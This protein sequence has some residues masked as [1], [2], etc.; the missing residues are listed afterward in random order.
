M[1]KH[2]IECGSILKEGQKFCSECG[3]KISE[4][5]PEKTESEKEIKKTQKDIEE[6]IE[7]SEDELEKPSVQDK[8]KIKN[9]SIGRGWLVFLVI[10]VISVI[11]LA[12]ILSQNNGLTPGPDG[13][14]PDPNLPD[15][16]GGG[17]NLPDE[18]GD[19]IPDSSDNCPT[20]YNPSQLDN[21]NDGQGDICDP[22]DDNDGYLDAN[23]Y[24]RTKNARLKITLEEFG[25][26]DEVDLFNDQAQVYFIVT[27]N[28]DEVERYPSG[29]NGR[30]NVLLY[31]NRVINHDIYYD[32]PDNKLTHTIL[33]QMY[34][35]D[36]F[37]DPSD[38]LLDL[39]GTSSGGSFSVY[40][41]IQTESWTGDDTTGFTDGS[42]DGTQS[43]DNDDAYLKYDIQMV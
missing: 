6:D 24:I 23:D 39:D 20:A 1:S 19:G 7:K 36:T 37:P 35:W 31:E 18:D 13:L 27:I 32:I 3:A 33:I 2:C 11:A 12:V 5:I 26:Y 30:M 38:D 8:E 21:D 42:R 40:Y 17:I 15:K 14:T 16:D 10:V 9:K 25:V 28:G 4:E 41:N 43:S 34:D 22:D 29:E